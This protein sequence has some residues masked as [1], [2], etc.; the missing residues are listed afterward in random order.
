MNYIFQKIN[1]INL[2]LMYIE[3][4]IAQTLKSSKEKTNK[5]IAQKFKNNNKKNVF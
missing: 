2:K 1:K 3:Q 4:N 5:Q